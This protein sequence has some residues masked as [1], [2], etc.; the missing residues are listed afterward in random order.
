MSSIG[1]H[2]ARPRRLD[3][4]N[5]PNTNYILEEELKGIEEE[6]K[7]EGELSDKVVCSYPFVFPIYGF[8][9]SVYGFSKVTAWFFARHFW[10]SDG[11]KNHSYRVMGVW[12]LWFF[13]FSE[14]EWT[15]PKAPLS[16]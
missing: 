16:P 5:T 6:G 2:R 3:E 9:K 10:S 11:P 1:F 14:P 12:H 13:N 15:G 4:F 7:R 8:L